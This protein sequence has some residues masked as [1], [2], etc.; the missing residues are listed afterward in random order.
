MNVAIKIL[1]ADIGGEFVPLTK[2]INVKERLIRVANKRA[3]QAEKPEKFHRC[4]LDQYE[5]VACR[6]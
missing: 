6:A 1:V 5:S 4:I 3:W 2:E